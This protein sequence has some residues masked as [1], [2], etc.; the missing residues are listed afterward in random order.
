MEE[1]IINDLK[2]LQGK[3]DTEAQHDL[4][5]RCLLSL[6]TRLGYKNVVEEYEKVDKWY[7]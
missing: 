7:A 4:A 5:D 2:S 6:L 3:G 1:E